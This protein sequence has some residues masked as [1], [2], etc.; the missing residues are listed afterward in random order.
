MHHRNR[1]KSCQKSICNC[2]RHKTAKQILSKKNK[3]RGITEPDFKINYK[4]TKIAWDLQKQSNKKSIQT[5]GAKQGTSKISS[6]IYGQLIFDKVNKKKM[7][8][9]DTLR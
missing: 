4:S 8:E 2:R 9:N 1:K 5:R 3:Y 6:H 7:W